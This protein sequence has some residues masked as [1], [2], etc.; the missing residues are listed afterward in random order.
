MHSSGRNLN[1]LD[2]NMTFLV[3]K[4]KVHKLSKPFTDYMKVNI[5]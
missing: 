1:R 5:R 4:S 2:P 3:E